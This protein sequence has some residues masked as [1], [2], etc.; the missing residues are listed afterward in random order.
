MGSNIFSVLIPS[1]GKKRDTVGLP[2]KLTT[3]ITNTEKKRLKCKMNDL[4]LK[5]LLYVCCHVDMLDYPRFKKKDAHF[6]PEVYVYN[7]TKGVVVHI[8][9]DRGCEL[10]F[11]HDKEQKDL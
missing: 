11:Q 6:P 8:Y 5:K 9:D 7:I 2:A 4:Y 1:K 3:T 10:M